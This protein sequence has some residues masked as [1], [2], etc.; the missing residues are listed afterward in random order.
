MSPADAF[1]EGAD[2]ARLP[3]AH[4][5]QEQASVLQ[6][7]AR[8]VREARVELQARRPGEERRGGLPFPHFGR[9]GL[10]VA[11]VG[12]IADD[13]VEALAEEGR[14][15]VAQ[16]EAH[17][18]L[19]KSRVGARRRER[20]RR[21]V[22]GGHGPS[23]PL[24]LE[25]DRQD[26]RAGAKIQRPPRRG[27][28]AVARQDLL[29]QLLGLVPGDEDGRIHPEG[30]PVEVAVAR[31]VREGLAALA[32]LEECLSRQ[33]GKLVVAFFA[34]GPYRYMDWIVTTPLLLAQ[35]RAAAQGQAARDLR[36]DRPAARSRRVDDPC[37]LH[38]RPADRPRRHAAHRQAS[39]LGHT[40]YAVGYLV[41]PYVL[42]FRLGPRYGG[43][44]D[45][46]SGH[47][48]RVL[49]FATVTTWG[50]YPLGYLATALFPKLDLNWI[51]LA[52][53][54]ADLVN[55]IGVGVVAYLAGAEALAR[56]TPPEAVQ[57]ARIST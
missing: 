6:V 47:A 41:L 23:G 37:R 54:V 30:A 2:L 36:L 48:F 10:V 21:E 15:A 44:S 55:K 26:A 3:V 33:F 12:W 52:Y 17:V 9:E 1:E 53:T 43:R 25:R 42:F 31:D 38:R 18:G 40:V 57:P 22:D 19:E 35:D 4:L 7:G 16:H 8:F 28:G 14:E 51:H 39:A 32:P 50:V 20:L 56:R 27:V 49:A 46:E 45:D 13:Q 5:Q 24:E 34:I 11:D 29:D